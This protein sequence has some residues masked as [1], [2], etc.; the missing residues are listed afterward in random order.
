MRDIF[1]TTPIVKI[2]K[3]SEEAAVIDAL[4]LAF[5]ADPATRWV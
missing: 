3:E 4:R 1:M 2:A 5:A